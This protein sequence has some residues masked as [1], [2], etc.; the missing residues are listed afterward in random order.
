MSGEYLSVIISACMLV[1]SFI[2]YNR[3]TATMSDNSTTVPITVE[4]TPGA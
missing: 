3:G 2:T 1:I 4:V